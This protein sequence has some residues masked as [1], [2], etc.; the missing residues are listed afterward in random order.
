MTT[1]K[2]R[3]F[4]LVFDFSSKTNSGQN[5]GWGVRGRAAAGGWGAL[6]FFREKKPRDN[7]LPVGRTVRGRAAAGGWGALV[8]P[9]KKTKGQ[10]PARGGKNGFCKAK[11]QYN[12]RAGGD[13]KRVLQSKSTIQCTRR[14]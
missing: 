11:A 7:N 10:Q 4:L 6:V 12:A 5:C 8:F 14:R 2:G 13:F 3:G 9:L 1:F